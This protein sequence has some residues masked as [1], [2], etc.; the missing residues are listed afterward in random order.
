MGGQ[1][2]GKRESGKAEIGRKAIGN[3]RFKISKGRN[4]ATGC[5][6]SGG[7]AGP[8]PWMG[9]GKKA[10]EREWGRFE[11]GRQEGRNGGMGRIK[12]LDTVADARTN[13]F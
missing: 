2:S 7:W 4:A 13:Y 10:G 12:L 3:F 8:V 1:K 6:H 5:R 11:L 9:P